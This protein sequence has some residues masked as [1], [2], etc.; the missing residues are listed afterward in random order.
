MF[1]DNNYLQVFQH[2]S[3]THKYLFVPSPYGNWRI[4]FTIGDADEAWITSGSAGTTCPASESAPISKR[5]GRKS[6]AY[7]KEGSWRDEGK[8][9]VTVFGESGDFGGSGESGETGE[10]SGSSGSGESSGSGDTTGS[11][12][13]R[14][15]GESSGSGDSDGSGESSE[16]SGSGDSGVS[17]GSVGSGEYGDGESGGSGDSGN[18]GG[19]GDLG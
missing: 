11:S 12:E 16:S 6:W 5:L 4:G 7:Y 9:T 1:I 15:S 3:G 2:E 14:G 18:F 19:S 10:S 8:I 13:F 17:G